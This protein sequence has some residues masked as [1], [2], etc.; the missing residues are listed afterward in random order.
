MAIVLTNG[1]HYITTDD[2]GKIKKVQDIEKAQPFYSCNV[3]M[4]KVIFNP[5]KM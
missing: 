5:K 3:A 4:R 1:Q 2:S